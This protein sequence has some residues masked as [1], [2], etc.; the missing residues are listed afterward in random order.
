MM[1]EPVRGD[2]SILSGTAS[3]RA[4]AIEYFMEE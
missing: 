3:I 1:V 2:P 4:E